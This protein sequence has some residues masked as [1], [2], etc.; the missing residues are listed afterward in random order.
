MS[1]PRTAASPAPSSIPTIRAAP[2]TMKTTVPTTTPLA[3]SRRRITSTTAAQETRVSS[4][5]SKARSTIRTASSGTV[6]YDDTSPDTSY[7][8]SDQGQFSDEEE[9]D[10]TLDPASGDDQFDAGDGGHETIVSNEQGSYPDGTSITFNDTVT[11]QYLDDDPG[12]DDESA[13]TM[14]EEDHFSDD[15]GGNDTPQVTVSGPLPGGSYTLTDNVLDDS[16]DV[17]DVGAEGP[18]DGTLPTE[19]GGDGLDGAGGQGGSGS[20]SGPRGEH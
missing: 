16:F 13:G 17:T 5:K 7:H 10:G 2:T 3:I 20:S 15:V 19:G 12:S 18:G 6:F 8:S 14:T 1:L 11:D 9:A 4:K